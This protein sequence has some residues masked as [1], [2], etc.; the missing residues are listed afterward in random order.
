MVVG[1]PADPEEEKKVLTDY[2]NKLAN[3]K[4]IDITLLKEAGD[5]GT[6]LGYTPAHLEEPMH[7]KKK[8]SHL[9]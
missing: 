6:L 4:T 7:L 3:F 2:Q 1:Q 9:L 5:G 8:I